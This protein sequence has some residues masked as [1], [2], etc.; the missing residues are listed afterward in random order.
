M[1]H[2]GQSCLPGREDSGQNQGIDNGGKHW[3]THIVHGNDAV[4][5]EPRETA[6]KQ[7][8]TFR[9]HSLGGLASSSSTGLDGAEKFTAMSN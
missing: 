6:S 7:G 8:N 2:K 9:G 5:I 4:N 1:K 3:D